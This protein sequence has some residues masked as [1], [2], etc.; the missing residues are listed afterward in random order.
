MILKILEGEFYGIN[1]QRLRNYEIVE[2]C[3][4]SPY[5]NLFLKKLEIKDSEL[6]LKFH[7]MENHKWIIEY[8]IMFDTLR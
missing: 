1:S 7:S 4:N 8:V 3:S 5:H 2:S 6:K